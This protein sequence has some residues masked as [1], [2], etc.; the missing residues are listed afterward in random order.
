MKKAKV[1]EIKSAGVLDGETIIAYTHSA[2]LKAARKYAGT[3][4]GGVKTTVR[5]SRACAY[6]SDL[7]KAYLDARQW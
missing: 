7:D 2:A 1:Y 6:A 4:R 5:I 3:Q